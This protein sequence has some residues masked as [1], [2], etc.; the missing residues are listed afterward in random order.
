[1]NEPNDPKLCLVM[2]RLLPEQV[3]TKFWNSTKEE[4]AFLWLDEKKIP[5]RNVL[6][7]E[8]L[9]VMQLVEDALK[10]GP[11]AGAEKYQYAHALYR[12]VPKGRQPCCATFNQRARAMCTVK[13][14]TP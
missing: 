11:D 5:T 7:T 9:Y 6:D 10:D 4:V 12:V 8:W 1:M 3:F 14:I 2:A 13:G